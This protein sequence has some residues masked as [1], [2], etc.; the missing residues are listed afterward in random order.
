MLITFQVDVYE[1]KRPSLVL[2]WMGTNALLIYVLIACNTLPV[3]LQGFYW[4]KPQNNIV[5]NF[6]LSSY[7][8][9]FFS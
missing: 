8:I 9:L 2:E 5:S 7:V 3:V 6:G 4:R 1:Y